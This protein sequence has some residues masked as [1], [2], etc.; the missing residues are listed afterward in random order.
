MP[1]MPT[2]DDL[3]QSTPISRGI[4]D[5]PRNVFGEGLKALGQGVSGLGDDLYRGSRAIIEEQKQQDDAVDYARAKAHW[6]KGAALLDNRYQLETDQD[7][8]TWSTRFSKDASTVR[9]QATD[10]IRNPNLRARFEAET[11]D[12]ETRYTLAIGERAR[13]IYRGDRQAKGEMAI[14]D[15]L[16]TA[17]MPTTP[18]PV[19]EKLLREMRA[20]IDNM[21]VSGV[22][23]PEQ[24]V[25]KRQAVTHAWGDGLAAND[26]DQ[27]PGQAVRRLSGG[28]MAVEAD[29]SLV[30]A[31]IGVESGGDPS[32]ISNKGA[33]GLMQILPSTAEDI[34]RD[35]G[36]QNFPYGKGQEAVTAYLQQGEVNAKYGKEY[37]DQ[38]LKRYGNQVTPA[39]AAYNWGQG[40][41]DKW[42]AEGANPGQLP[43]ET[44]DYIEKVM[45]ATNVAPAYY[46][47]FV[48]PQ[49]RARI[50]SSATSQHEQRRRVNR[51]ALD[52]AKYNTRQAMDD[53]IAQVELTG[54]A[55]DL[56]PET[57]A[58]T[59]GPDDGLKFAQRRDFAKSQF[60]VTSTMAG[61]PSDQLPGYVRSLEPAPG[62]SNFEAR[63]KIYDAA[64]RQADKLTKTRLEDPAESVSTT[65]L[66][67]EAA[68]GYSPKDPQSVQR[69]IKARLAA[70]DQ[71][72]IRG[73]SQM[74]ATKQEARAIIRPIENVLS[75]QDAQVMAAIANAGTP[76]LARSETKRIREQAK[77]LI[78]QT[79]DH[80]Q[81][82]YGPYSEKVL[83]Q[84]IDASVREKDIGEL[85]T[86]MLRKLAKGERPSASDAQAHDNLTDTIQAS[87]AIN[88][89]QLA[90]T[91]KPKLMPEQASNS[92]GKGGK[93]PGKAPAAQPGTGGRGRSTLPGQGAGKGGG[94]FNNYTPPQSRAATHPGYPQV[95]KGAV[96]FLVANPNSAA[97]FDEIYGPGESKNWLPKGE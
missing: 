15:M 47:Q 86:Q 85:T 17:M 25:Q 72:G 75:E 77:D 8:S 44:R 30:K 40:N 11:S 38:L 95:G 52:L 28:S 1:K 59:L 61:M 2:Q 70:Q 43:T 79:I 74:V 4:V 66:V 37:L 83:A 54:Q 56:T 29:P 78:R 63:K 14:D 94:R 33:V 53:D 23:T 91:N 3:Q 69:L 16:T 62:S 22:Y 34:A 36:D 10:L 55:T 93:E 49:A 31:V 12:D 41:V 27:N 18:G 21:A 20:S 89:Q 67:K 64:D 82:L 45:R 42:M 57:V 39:L 51:D 46:D 58:A 9:Q 5:A 7:Y 76:T 19:R 65:A 84:A 48:T 13:T 90:P 97:Q 88:G 68:K 50:L 32:A 24:A 71:V 35:I 87:K 92:S 80:V 96:D 60:E 6:N 26:A 73:Q 81:E